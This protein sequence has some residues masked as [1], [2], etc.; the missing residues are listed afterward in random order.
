[1]NIALVEPDPLLRQVLTNAVLRLVPS[2]RILAFADLYN[3]RI[4]LKQWS[5]QL[6]VLSAKLP[7]GDGFDL[8]KSVGQAIKQLPVL[9]LIEQ[10]DRIT[11][12]RAKKYGVNSILSKP[13]N[14]HKV[15][16]KLAELLPNQ[17]KE[18]GQ[19]DALVPLEGFIVEQIEQSALRLSHDPAIEKDLSML[20][21]S[22][23]PLRELHQLARQSTVLVAYLIAEANRLSLS[24]GQVIESVPEAIKALG[25]A[26]G[27]LI[28]QQLLLQ[29]H[30]LVHPGLVTLAR[31]YCDRMQ[32]IAKTAYVLAKKY[33]ADAEACFAACM[34]IYMGELAVLRLAQAWLDKGG[35][36]HS[37]SLEALTKVLARFG[38][39]A[40]N[41]IKVDLHLPI[42]VRELTGAV[43]LMP[44]GIIRREKLITRLA[45]LMNLADKEQEIM[46]VMR[47]LGAVPQVSVE[48]KA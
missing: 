17:P 34:M 6:L 2:A 35:Q 40:G 21:L 30:G 5:V 22:P 3:A 24:N 13:F 27:L 32:M 47:H 39:R 25:S 45:S 33:Q 10:I 44:T 8:L 31:D 9:L 14:H 41:K 1:M 38:P 37:G 43:H 15:L 16:S 48:R 20:T 7:D 26:R 11:V 19:T 36:W 18:A 29:S 46:E 28:S 12:I 42:A 4:E 23:S